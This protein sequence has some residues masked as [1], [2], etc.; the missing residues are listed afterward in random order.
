[1]AIAHHSSDSLE[2][3]KRQ[4]I[5]FWFPVKGCLKLQMYEPESMRTVVFSAITYGK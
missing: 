5:L 4:K 2:H 3:E 1:M